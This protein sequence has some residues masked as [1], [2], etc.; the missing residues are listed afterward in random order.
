M[1]KKILF[2]SIL[3]C[4]FGSLFAKDNKSTIDGYDGT[5]WR[6]TAWAVPG[7]VEAE[8]FDLGGEGVAYHESD[9]SGPGG[10][11][12]EYR[13]DDEG[14]I[15]A[16]Y[17]DIEYQADRDFY[18]L[19][20]GVA[21]EWVNYTINVTEEGLYDI[22]VVTA[23]INNIAKYSLSL[24]FVEIGSY[25]FPNTGSWTQFT[26]NHVVKA[27]FLPAGE[28]VFTFTFGGEGTTNVLNIDK[29]IF[30]KAYL[31]TA[32]GEYTIPGDLQ[33][34]NFDEGGNGVAYSSP[35]G[36]I[37]T[38]GSGD[39]TYIVAPAGGWLKYTFDV[40]ELP[41]R[42][43]L[44]SVNVAT[45]KTE[46]LTVLL[47]GRE[48]AKDI[49]IPSTGSAFQTIELPDLVKIYQGENVITIQTTGGNFDKFSLVK[50][51]YAGLPY[52][53][54]P[55]EIPGII[56]A[57]YFDIGGEGISFHDTN[58]DHSQAKANEVRGWIGDGSEVVQM[59]NN[60]FEGET[61][62]D[63][64]WNNN[65]EWLIYTVNI[66]EAA[67]YDI[68]VVTA[69]NNTTYHIYYDLDDV[70]IC[71]FTVLTASHATF[72]KFTLQKIALPA[73]IHYLKARV[74]GNANLEKF[75]F[76]KSYYGE[77]FNGPHEVPGEIEAEDF[78]TA[79]TIAQG[80]NGETYYNPGT[81]STPNTYRPDV[82]IE[83]GGTDGDR[84]INAEEGEWLKYTIV[85]PA[86]TFTYYIVSLM[87]ANTKNSSFDVYLDG[88]L[89]EKD[90]P[91][92]NTG[93]FSNYEESELTE[94]LLITGGTH[95]FE[96]HVKS[97][98][99]D[100]INIFESFY[101]GR[102]FFD[103][104][105]KIAA[106]GDS[107]IEA[108]Y[109]DIGG[110][111]ISFHDNSTNGGTDG[112]KVDPVTGEAPGGEN[113]VPLSH[114]VRAGADD[115][116]TNVCM[117]YRTADGEPIINIG[118]SNDGEWVAYS[119]DVEETGIYDIWQFISTANDNRANHV[120]VD[121]TSY[122]AIT[123]RTS[124]WE[125]FLW[126]A[127][128]GKDNEG[129]ELTAGPHVLYVYYNGNFDKIKI[130]KHQGS[131]PYEGTPQEIPGIVEAWKFDEGGQ[132]ISYSTSDI[133]LGGENNAIRTD[134][135]VEIKSGEGG[136]YVFDS[137]GGSP[138]WTKYAV[139]VKEAGSYKATFKVLC[140]TGNETWTLSGATSGSVILAN[141][142]GATRERATLVEFAK[143]GIQ[144]LLITHSGSVIGIYSV[145][146]EKY[147]GYGGTPVHGVPYIVKADGSPVVIQAEDFD[148]GGNKISYYETS[149]NDG[150]FEFTN[151]YRKE[152]GDYEALVPME[153]HTGTNSDGINIGWTSAGEWGAYTIEVEETG[154][155]DFTA[156]LSTNNDDRKEH[157]K[158]DD[159]EYP[160]V[161]FHTSGWGVYQTLP[162]VEQAPITA[163]KHVV[164]FYYDGNI[165]YFTI[166]KNLTDA[167]KGLNPLSG[168]VYVDKA[169]NLN[170]KGFSQAASIAVYN[171][172]GQKIADRKITSDNVQ[173]PL[174][175]KGIYLVKVQDKGTTVSYK[176]I[177]N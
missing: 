42:D 139:D 98:H 15:D 14:N 173:T 75:I 120:K 99:L 95:K 53:G 46:K 166:G 156:T 93:S 73:G 174:P 158:I 171:L 13:Y 96:V 79:P 59:E 145:T 97:G 169:G 140:D 94:T 76:E 125:S 10:M 74:S 155:Y 55:Y 108:E 2:L 54:D 67:T 39:A 83:I 116:S 101:L 3:L 103:E 69:T 150:P 90:V 18:D 71:D 168:T 20:S 36:S 92:P 165:D 87:W 137:K 124:A 106:E 45:T 117:E 50:P 114:F 121:N 81:I 44:V 68:S 164:Y 4:G 157:F 110:R 128:Q 170:V 65:E 38:G 64:G 176:V 28:H 41:F 51:P 151:S 63:I 25:E 175:A 91:I 109:F 133:T 127:H 141:D 33:A 30:E 72:Q 12:G 148:K 21:G 161:I 35:S 49:D 138:G 134:S 26:D 84:Y 31:G 153:S 70:Q 6:G 34:E 152:L 62:V 146:F 56:E 144:E 89:I 100:K 130:T 48:I 172:L 16:P 113:A 102:P 126:F 19:G 177:F 163:G 23:K 47:N 66:L 24:D 32:K 104:A 162:V 82:N 8:D 132:G 61:I 143:A 105:W 29:F 154:V 131:S 118:W 147:D 78:D 52:A 60:T 58:T 27:V 136:Y 119:I 159:V 122:P 80:G 142:P 135:P 111:E 123:V 9:M 1:K 115:G 85:A 11:A 5:P 149:G 37:E 43:F 160:E 22:R 107:F 86:N 129:I 167:I 17:V 112:T 88:R 77:P 7:V 40:P 57:E